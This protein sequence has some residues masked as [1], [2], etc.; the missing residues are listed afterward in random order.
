MPRP[1]M[2]PILPQTMSPP[3]F[4]NGLNLPESEYNPASQALT[5]SPCGLGNSPTGS[6]TN[7][8]PQVFRPIMAWGQGHPWSPRAKNFE[9]NSRSCGRPFQARHCGEVPDRRGLRLTGTRTEDRRIRWP[10]PPAARLPEGSVSPEGVEARVV[11]SYGAAG[12]TFRSRARLRL[13][14]GI[15]RGSG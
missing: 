5:P 12:G 8:K 3:V 2:F 15:E 10:N 1:R 13:M 7:F 9:K 14:P 4:F 11:G 6:R